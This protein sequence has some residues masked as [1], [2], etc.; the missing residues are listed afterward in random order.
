MYNRDDKIVEMYGQPQVGDG[1]KV[2]TSPKASLIRLK[3]GSPDVG[4]YTGLNPAVFVVMLQ[5]MN[6]LILEA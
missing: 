2:N 3:V 1:V 5:T 4:Q 6:I